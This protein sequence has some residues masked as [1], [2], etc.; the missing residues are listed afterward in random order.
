MKENIVQKLTS[1]D[2]KYACAFTDRIV[3]QY[4]PQ[5]LSALRSA[6]LSKYKDSM[7]PLIE[8]DMEETEKILMNSGFMELISLN[9]IFYFANE[10]TE[11]KA[12]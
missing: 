4:I 5:I 1:K 12:T 9:D 2:D 3:A 6:D 10:N 8:R 11:T 7:R